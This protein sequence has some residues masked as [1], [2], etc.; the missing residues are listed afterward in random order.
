MDVFSFNIS[1]FHKLRIMVL[2]CVHEFKMCFSFA[3][4]NSYSVK[5]DVCGLRVACV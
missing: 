2:A 1:H 5:K 4:V 3:S